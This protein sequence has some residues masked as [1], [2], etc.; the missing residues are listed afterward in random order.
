MKKKAS[1]IIVMTFFGLEKIFLLFYFY[2]FSLDFLMN[3]LCEQQSFLYRP[4]L[5]TITLIDPE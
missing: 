1:M 3:L 4:T 5:V 2:I